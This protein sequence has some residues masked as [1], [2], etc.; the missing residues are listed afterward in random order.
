M[1]A[2]S[3]TRLAVS[4]HGACGNLATCEALGEPLN[5][6]NG[7]VLS[8]TFAADGKTLGSASDDQTFRFWDVTTHEPIGKSLES[9]YLQIAPSLSIAIDNSWYPI[10]SA[11]AKQTRLCFELRLGTCDRVL[12]VFASYCD[13]RGDRWKRCLEARA[14]VSNPH[15]ISGDLRVAIPVCPKRQRDGGEFIHF[16]HGEAVLR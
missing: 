16:G 3:L 14:Q 11:L 6:H 4:E 15:D 13:Q 7:V 10:A 12:T 9:G 8:T 1:N 2:I 5:D